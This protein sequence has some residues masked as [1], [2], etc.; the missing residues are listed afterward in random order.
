MVIDSIAFLQ[1]EAVEAS[2]EKATQGCVPAQS[3]AQAVSAVKESLSESEPES[4]SETEAE[5]DLETEAESDSEAEMV[6]DNPKT[7]TETIV[8]DCDDQVHTPVHHFATAYTY[9]RSSLQGANS[10]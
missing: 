8:I 6:E 4:G 2:I 10:V 7:G 9:C 3:G 5:S 1:P